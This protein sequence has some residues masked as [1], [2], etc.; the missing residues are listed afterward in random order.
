MS[1]DYYDNED[2]RPEDPLDSEEDLRDLEREE[3]VVEDEIPEVW[4]ADKI[5]EIENPVIREQEIEAAE[6]LLEEE[7]ELL[8]K[9]EAGEIDGPTFDAKYQHELSSKMR[10]AATRSGLESTGLTWDHLGDLAEDNRF[11]AKGD[12]EL[13]D[14]KDHLKEMIRELGP[15]A[16][17]ELADEMLGEGRIGEEA[18]ET[19]SR[20]VRLHRVSSE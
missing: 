3:N 18:H 5:R 1:D 8:R 15:D 16:S 6:K 12:T 10:R 17:Q 9:Y 14:Q 11:L 4:W 20:Q 19:I 7:K 13:L 2:N